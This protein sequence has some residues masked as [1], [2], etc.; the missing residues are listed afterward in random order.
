VSSSPAALLAWL[1]IAAPAEAPPGRAVS[2]EEILEAMRRSQGYNLEATTNGARLQAE[3]LLRLVREA[4]EGDPERRPLFI[5]HEPW[6]SAYLERTG[7]TAEQAPL[8]E[9][10]AY[11]H[12]QDVEIDYRP[13]RVIES[14]PDPPPEVAANVIVWW[15]ARPGG[16]KSYS[17]EDFLSTPRLKVTNERVITYR[18]LERDGMMVFGDVEGLRG[19]PTT[20]LLGVLFRLIGEGHVVE[21]R[22]IISADGLQISRARAR[23]A[24]FEVAPTVTVFPDGRTEKDVPPG[25]PDLA[26]LDERLRKPLE[27]RYRPLDPA[28]RRR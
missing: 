16:P 2:R 27:I 5:G 14:V 23:K 22:M 11:E 28:W 18:L 12:G 1:L 20:G 4:R 8:F 9:R 26:T 7:L 10:L 13:E 3:V 15:P 25:R 24:F 19:R 17:Y 21:S 6:F